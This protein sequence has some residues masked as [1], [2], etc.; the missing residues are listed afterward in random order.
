MDEELVAKMEK[1]LDDMLAAK[2]LMTV[3]MSDALLGL[4]LEAEMV[5]NLAMKLD[6]PLDAIM[7]VTMDVMKVG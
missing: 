6:K 7:V 2:D 3:V 4:I 1:L 5:G